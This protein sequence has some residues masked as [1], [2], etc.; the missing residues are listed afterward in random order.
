MPSQRVPLAKLFKARLV[1]R[2]G[3]WLPGV[4]ALPRLQP[5]CLPGGSALLKKLDGS[6][7]SSRVLQRTGL[8]ELLHLEVRGATTSLACPVGSSWN[9]GEPVG[10]V[11]QGTSPLTHLGCAS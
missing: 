6:A 1:V 9:V 11:C 8:L 7:R 2:L 10:G 4:E 3:C 5:F